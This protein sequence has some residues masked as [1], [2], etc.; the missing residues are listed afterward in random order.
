M[1]AHFEE[2][3]PGSNAR[4]MFCKAHPFDTLWQIQEARFDPMCFVNAQALSRWWWIKKSILKIK[5]RGSKKKLTKQ[6]KVHVAAFGLTP[7]SK[8]PHRSCVPPQKDPPCPGCEWCCLKTW[9]F[10]FILI[11]TFNCFIMF[12]CFKGHRGRCFR[13]L[14]FCFHHT[15]FGKCDKHQKSK[16]LDNKRKTFRPSRH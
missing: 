16:Q 10:C 14:I 9:S 8:A 15:Q 1:R 13:G 3:P 4:H 2:L 5:L 7:A 6:T 11:H 12:Q